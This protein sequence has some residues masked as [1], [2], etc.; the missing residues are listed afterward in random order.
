MCG[1]SETLRTPGY[2][3]ASRRSL[4]TPVM[5]WCGSIRTVRNTRSRCSVSWSNTASGA[6]AGTGTCLAGLPVRILAEQVAD[7]VRGWPRP[8]ALLVAQRLPGYRYVGEG[9]MSLE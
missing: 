1:V 7:Q 4:R 3:S 2:L 9:G 8:Q 6:E 5:P